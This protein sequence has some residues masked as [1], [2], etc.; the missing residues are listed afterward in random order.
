[1]SENFMLHTQTLHGGWAFPQA[2]LCISAM[3]DRGLTKTQAL[4]F[5]TRHQKHQA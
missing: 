3:E 5:L 2:L 1:M 4:C